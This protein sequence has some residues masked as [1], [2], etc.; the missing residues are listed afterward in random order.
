MAISLGPSGLQLNDATHDDFADFEGG[1]KVLQLSQKV[2]QLETTFNGTNDSNGA[3]V[4]TSLRH[5][6]TP[7]STSSKILYQINFLVGGANNCYAHFWLYRKIGSGSFTKLNFSTS[8]AND[9]IKSSFC[10]PMNSA[11]GQHKPRYTSYQFL[12][13]PSTTSQVTYTLYAAVHQTGTAL[14]IGRSSFHNNNNSYNSHN[15][16]NIFLTE[17]SG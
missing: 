17:I 3:E 4:S 12:D 2:V 11:D 8:S 1:G 13:S 16:T 14:S 7:S 15:P 5:S 10:Q 6:I 9:P